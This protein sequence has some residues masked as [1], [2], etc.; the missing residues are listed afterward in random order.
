[1][2]QIR[3]G[4]KLGILGGGQL[5][6][7][8]ALSAHNIGLEPHIFSEHAEDPAQQVTNH[9]RVGSL[10]NPRDLAHFLSKVDFAT[11]ES[12]FLNR[13]LLI[14]VSAHAKCVFAPSPEVM[15]EI[16]D[17][18]T[19]KELLD[20]FKVPTSPW[21]T[22]GSRESCEEAVAKLKLPLVFKK[23]RFGYDGYGTFIVKTQ[24][25]VDNFIEKHVNT[26]GGFIAE[27]FVPFKRELACIFARNQGGQIV[28]YPLMESLQKDARCFWVK[29][30]I[31]HP[32]FNAW[33]TKFK[34]LLAE[35]KY[36][37][38]IAAE[39]FDSSKGLVVNELAPRVH[40][41]GHITMDAFSIS[42]FE[43]HLRAI[44]NQELKEP[45]QLGKGFAMVNLL[46]TT[47]PQQTWE[48][49][50][51]VNL[52]WYGKND[53]RP[54]RKMGHLNVVDSSPDKALKIA[55]KA[56]KGFSI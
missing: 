20:K 2:S 19:Q 5:A 51:N 46:G 14:K 1:V 54:G 52:H 41:S 56:L 13:D 35:T 27:K 16:Q 22:V 24:G 28:N 47:S 9:G 26:E 50:P 30:P 4:L 29:G 15:A 8:I 39:L 38:V 10:N 23:R 34:K 11:Y 18:R 49:V 53:S 37:G 25:D 7:M 40:N 48:L 44:L 3:P 31:K 32:K 43:L 12:E 45:Q 42:Q 17:R 33:A 36:V 21:M 6:R 55:M